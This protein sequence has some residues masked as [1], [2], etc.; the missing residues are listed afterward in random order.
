MRPP[1]SLSHAHVS[2][3]FLSQPCSLGGPDSKSP[4]GLLL[5]QTRNFGVGASNS[6]TLLKSVELNMAVAGEVG[7]NATVS[8]IGT[9]AAINSTLDN[10][11]VDNAA[12]EVQAFG[13]GVCP[14]VDE[15]LADGLD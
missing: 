8:A 2:A 12:V 1:I 4:G 3:H 13:L 6:S 15:Q 7:R 5:G 9:P 11:V 14:Q 10:N